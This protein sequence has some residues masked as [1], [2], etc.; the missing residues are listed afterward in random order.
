MSLRTRPYNWLPCLAF[1]FA[2]L[3]HGGLILAVQHLGDTDDPSTAVADAAA[4]GTGGIEIE[5]GMAG[6]YQDRAATTAASTPV[7]E[8]RPEPEPAPVT[9]EAAAPDSVTTTPKKSR[10]KRPA[11]K[12]AKPASVPAA[13]PAPAIT[14]E[15]TA[16]PGE[17]KDAQTESAMVKA[18]GTGNSQRAGGVTGDEKNYFSELKRWLD[19][20]KDYP[21]EAKKQKQQGTVVVRFSINRKGDITSATIKRSS[22]NSLLDQAALDLLK[23]ASPVPPIPDSMARETLSVAIPID[24]SLLTR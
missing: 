3:L 15:K 22:G 4:D 9:K 7:P 24:Y 13:S 20:H 8:T 5:L 23:K 6:A 19:R 18:S 17:G 10:P 14:P 21:A 1:G 16:A 11:E 12:T 2:L